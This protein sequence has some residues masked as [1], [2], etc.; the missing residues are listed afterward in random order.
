MIEWSSVTSMGLLAGILV[1]V[2][3]VRRRFYREVGT[4]RGS[5]GVI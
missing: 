4:T 3:M 1:W 5:R 2:L